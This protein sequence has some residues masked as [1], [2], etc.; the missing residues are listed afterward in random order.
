MSLYVT[1]VLVPSKGY[2]WQC[3][4]CGQTFHMRHEIDKHTDVMLKQCTG[5]YYQ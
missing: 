4:M 3:R 5:R 1:Q 2:M